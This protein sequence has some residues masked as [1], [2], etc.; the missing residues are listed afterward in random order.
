MF[1]SN[2]GNKLLNDAKFCPNCGAAVS[3]PNCTEAK[4]K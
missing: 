4:V 2:C 1:C 3:N